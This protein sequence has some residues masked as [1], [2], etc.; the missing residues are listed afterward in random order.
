MRLKLA[1]RS[2]EIFVEHEVIRSSYIPPTPTFEK[3][4]GN[5][6]GKITLFE[7]TYCKKK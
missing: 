1:T 2:S 5:E 3:Y 7:V 4:V 6:V